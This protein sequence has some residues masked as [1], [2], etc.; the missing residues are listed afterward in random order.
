MAPWN[1]TSHTPNSHIFQIRPRMRGSKVLELKCCFYSLHLPET[2]SS[3]LAVGIFP[4]HRFVSA[5]FKVLA[6]PKLLKK[7]PLHNTARACDNFTLHD[8]LQFLQNMDF[9]YVLM[10]L[11]ICSAQAV[12]TALYK[13][14]K[15]EKL[16]HQGVHSLT[17]DK[18][19]QQMEGN[20]VG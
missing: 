9:L 12:C 7:F 18:E 10:L 20:R 1:A 4:P 2:L 16:L 6:M 13:G 5:I 3:D 14:H 11:F 8:Y 17:F 19:Y 15:I